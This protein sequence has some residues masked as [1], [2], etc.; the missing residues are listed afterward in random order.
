MQIPFISK[1]ASFLP[2]EIPLEK[3][4]GNPNL[5][6]VQKV[7]QVARQ[8]ESLLLKKILGQANKP[9]SEG[10]GVAGGIY[11]DMVNGQLANSISQSG[12]LGLATALKGQ[13]TRQTLHQGQQAHVPASGAAHTHGPTKILSPMTN[14]SN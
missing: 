1:I 2:S 5:S 11:N 12:Q 8:F 4:A 13:L 14:T 6:E 10:S 9:M 7:A 3:L